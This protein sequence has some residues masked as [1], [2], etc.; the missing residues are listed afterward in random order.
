MGGDGEEEVV[1][2]LNS[3]T[4]TN[5]P[6]PLI[7]ALETVAP[8]DFAPGDLLRS[9]LGFTSSRCRLWLQSVVTVCAVV[10]EGG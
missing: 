6:V 5:A 1:V 7:T 10:V 8:S 4:D 2:L 3:Y 9:P